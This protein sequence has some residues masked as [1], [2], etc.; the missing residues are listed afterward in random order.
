MPMPNP[1]A[2]A[3]SALTSAQTDKVASAATAS[4]PF[5]KMTISSKNFVPVNTGQTIQ[6]ESAAG[7]AMNN[8]GHA[9]SV[10]PSDFGGYMNPYSATI[11]IEK[12]KRK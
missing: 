9:N 6:G 7:D 8:R 1:A 5:E 12:E 2:D 11:D 3:K 10:D 4:N